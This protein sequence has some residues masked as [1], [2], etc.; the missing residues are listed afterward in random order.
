MAQDDDAQGS[1]QCA[2]KPKTLNL[3][4]L[5]G[6]VTS[7]PTT[8][9]TVYLYG[10]RAS[11]YEVLE[12]LTEAEPSARFRALLPCIASF[13]ETKGFKEERQPIL[14][15]ELD[16]LSDSDLDAL[17]DAY[18]AKMQHRMRADGDTQEGPPRREPGEAS[19]AYVD[20]VLKHAVQVQLDQFRK[21]REKMLASTSSIF[22]QVRKSSSALGST[23]SAF[24]QLAKSA[25][26]VE[27]RAPIPDHFHAMNEQFARQA[28]ERAE[29]LE[30][31]RLTGK[32]TAESA[33]TLKDLAEAATVLLEQLD[34]R[35]KRADK[36]TRKQITIAVWSVV[37]SAV[38][39]LFA[40]IFSGLAYFQDKSDN[41]TGDRWQ[42]KLIAA[43]RE[44]SQQ[45]DAAGK[46]AQRL[47]DQVA[48]LE[49]K[50]MRL[51][52]AQTAALPCNSADSAAC[53]ATSP[54]S[55]LPAP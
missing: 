25:A 20:R 2:P 51:E 31:V 11:D 30:I 48:E 39:A 8:V 34:E 38:L 6:P 22:D 33:K 21:M 17:A 41:A 35:D 15:E 54:S 5:F 52:A 1:G 49:A 24:G 18:A 26:P 10:L 36:S 42:S 12:K 9:G 44:G 23:L 28:R 13:V 16:R 43:V 7:V 55:T 37:I 3:D 32:M 29:E 46:E 40:L 19:T 53:R 4:L 50:I 27:I 14:P 45:R 47:R